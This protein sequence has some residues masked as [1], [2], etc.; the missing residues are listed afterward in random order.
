MNKQELIEFLQDEADRA[1]V[2]LFPQILRYLEVNYF[3]GEEVTVP[4]DL[5]N[6]PK[7]IQATILG[8]AALRLKGLG[9]TANSYIDE[10]GNPCL[11]VS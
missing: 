5:K 1:L 11:G 10:D 2:D 4:L 7:N 9:Y 8:S 3:V 6:Y